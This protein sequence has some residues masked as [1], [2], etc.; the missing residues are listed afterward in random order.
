MFISVSS[1]LARS[2]AHRL[3][4]GSAAQVVE[5]TGL[6]V[7]VSKRGAER[8]PRDPQPERGPRG[9]LRGAGA[10]CTY[11]SGAEA[12]RLLSYRFGADSLQ[13]LVE[14]KASIKVRTAGGSN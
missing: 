13:V 7:G 5:I 14:I 1:H 6:Q 2:L 3:C 12:G 4:P 10:G 8:G 11:A 9:R